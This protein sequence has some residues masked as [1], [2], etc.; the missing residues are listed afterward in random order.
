MKKISKAIALAVSL[1]AIV[2]AGCKNMATDI[3]AEGTGLGNP[4]IR[5]ITIIATG[6]SDLI[7]FPTAGNSRSILAESLDAE[8]MYFYLSYKNKIGSSETSTYVKDPLQFTAQDADHPNIG[9]VP[10]TLEDS[11]YEFTLYATKDEVTG[12]TGVSTDIEKIKAKAVL[13]GTTS[14]DLRTS[15]DRVHFYLTPDGLPGASSASLNLFTTG[16]DL[17]TEHPGYTWQAELRNTETNV[18]ISDTTLPSTPGTSLPTAADPSDTSYEYTLASI[19]AGTYNF[20]VTFTKDTQSYS[21]SDKIVFLSNNPIIKDIAIPDVIEKAP[22]A[23]TNFRVSFKDPLSKESDYYYAGFSWTDTSNN[24]SYFRIELAKLGAIATP[25]GASPTI[26]ASTTEWGST[27]DTTSYIYKNGVTNDD[28]ILKY[29]YDFAG[30][31]ECWVDGSLHKNNTFAVFKLPLGDRYLARICSVNDAGDSAFC[32]IDLT[33][34][35]T[36]TGHDDFNKFAANTT[37]IN[38]YRLTYELMGGTLVYEDGTSTLDPIIEYRTQNDA[39]N[40]DAG[41]FDGTGTIVDGTYVKGSIS[42]G[43]DVL[44]ADIMNPKTDTETITSLIRNENA[45]TYWKKDAVNAP[46]T[47]GLYGASE[48]TATYNPADY[49]GYTNLILFACYRVDSADVTINDLT[50]YNITK[51]NISVS[52]T[53]IDSSELATKAYVKFNIA[54]ASAATV[55]W[56][57]G[58]T[59]EQTTRGIKWDKVK[60]SVT[61]QGETY[62]RIDREMT[63][64][65]SEGVSTFVLPV[66]MNTLPI[67]KYAVTFSAYSSSTYLS[68]YAAPYTYTVYVEILEG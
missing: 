64:T 11:Y 53:G 10:L 61:K 7:K 51:D 41:S 36:L 68:G 6:E 55:T 63:P 14:A 37:T 4:G 32:Y 67:G 50:Q 5:E 49:T 28:S 38:R 27:S 52:G 54:T 8:A 17:A 20:V 23:P 26:S 44:S 43:T 2:F 59:T 46:I 45:W 56:T 24:E 29:G 16:W 60:L 18:V 42:S 57:V 40:A 33:T 13:K 15:Y 35:A 66:T 3:V 12:L 34:G 39:T 31:Q 47:T 1:V 21:W 25:F 65:I 22:E 30:N 48:Y 19:T 58:Y 9:T 62:K